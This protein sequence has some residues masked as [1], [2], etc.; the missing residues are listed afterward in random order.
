MTDP[1]QLTINDNQTLRN[2]ENSLFKWVIGALIGI[3]FTLIG[4][5]YG[6]LR[7]ADAS[8]I[9]S[10]SE[11]QSHQILDASRFQ[12]LEANVFIICKSQK[13]NCIPPMN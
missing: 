11:I 1:T 10:I 9:S 8:A 6:F 4:I 5:L 7:S 13:L 2:E 3:L 12:N